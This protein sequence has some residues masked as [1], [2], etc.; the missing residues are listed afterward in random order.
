MISLFFFFFIIYKPITTYYFL[1]IE[2]VHERI[3]WSFK[4]KACSESVLCQMRICRSNLWFS[5]ITLSSL[6]ASLFY[7]LFLIVLPS[8]F[9]FLLLTNYLHIN[10]CLFFFSNCCCYSRQ[11][12]RF[13]LWY[14]VQQQIMNGFCDWWQ[15]TCCCC[16]CGG[17]YG[18]CLAALLMESG[19]NVLRAF[20]VSLQFDFFSRVTHSNLFLQS[21]AIYV[22]CL[23][24]I[25]THCF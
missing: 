9:Q 10:F 17:W 15:Y 24:S 13:D 19:K 3:M 18:G 4:T 2:G 6:C 20:W 11:H 5:L 16:H 12:W 22:I 7:F 23:Y 1:L 14:M 25:C 21:K 8:S